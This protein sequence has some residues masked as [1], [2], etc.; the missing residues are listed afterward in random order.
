MVWTSEDLLVTYHTIF[1]DIQVRKIVLIIIKT[2]N[3][4]NI[5]SI[6]KIHMF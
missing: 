1:Y 6:K 4:D 5:L 2:N 3:Y